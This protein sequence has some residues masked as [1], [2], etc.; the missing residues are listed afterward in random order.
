VTA[1][2]LDRPRGPKAPRDQLA[3]PAIAV[4]GLRKRYGDLVVLDGL[5]LEIGRGELFALLGPNGAG[6]TTTVEILEGYRR[7]DAGDVRVLGLDPRHSARALRPRVGLMLQDGG[8]PSQARPRELLRLHAAFYADPAEPDALLGLVGLSGA[9]NR[10]Y[11]VLS[12]GERQRLSLG[13][14]LVGRPEMLILDEPTA[15]MDPAAKEAVREL[16]GEL[17]SAG[18]TILL[19]TH[20]LADAERLADRVG[21]LDRGRL[22]ALGSPSDLI[23]GGTPRLRFGLGAALAAVDVASLEAALGGTLDPDGQPGRYCLAGRVPEPGLVAMLAT[24]AAERGLLLH[25]V[26]TS[27]GSLEERFLELVRDSEDGS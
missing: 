18:R 15:G 26:R 19:T 12:G 6:K 13:L 3:G 2:D 14:A 24:W 20:E 25:E 16:I 11:R 7:P 22:V 27:G 10:P 9:A 4:R 5:D 8:I 23:A 1:S 17:R 21:V